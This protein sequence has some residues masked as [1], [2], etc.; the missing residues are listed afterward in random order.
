MTLEQWHI[1]HRLR[2]ILMTL[3]IIHGRNRRNIKS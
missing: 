2:M 3:R 1:R